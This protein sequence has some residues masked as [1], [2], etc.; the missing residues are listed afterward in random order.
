MARKAPESINRL[1]L[2]QQFALL[3]YLETDYVSSGCTDNEFAKRASDHLGFTITGGNIFGCREA[4]NM[5]SNRDIRI[6]Q[7]KQPKNRLEAIEQK[8]EKLEAMA[9]EL[10]WK[11]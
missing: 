2:S 11:I 3:K 6:E 5:K 9:R 8:L 7:A 4:L 1:V 10:G